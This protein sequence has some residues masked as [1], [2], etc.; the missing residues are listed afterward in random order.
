MVENRGEMAL[1]H[2]MR[3]REIVAG[4]ELLVSRLRLKGLPTIEAEE[5][6]G[7]FRV[8]LQIFEEDLTAINAEI[9]QTRPPA[10]GG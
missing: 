4:Q 10:S 6:L 3:G 5:I 7:N 8:S 9:L 2:V 1:R